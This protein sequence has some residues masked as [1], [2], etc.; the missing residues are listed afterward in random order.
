VVDDDYQR[1]SVVGQ[2]GDEHGRPQRPGPRQRLGDHGG[3]EVEQCPLVAGVAA[4]HLTYMTPDV[5]VSIVD[6]DRPPTARRYPDESLT[7]PG[8]G[9]NS[10]GD[11]F[12]G[13]G[14][15]EL[16]SRAEDED[17]PD[18]LRNRTG[19]HRKKREI[20][21]ACPIDDRPFD[22]E[23]EP[24]TGI[25][26][27]HDFSRRPPAGT[28][29]GQRSPGTTRPAGTGPRRSGTEVI[30]TSAKAVLIPNATDNAQPDLGRPAPRTRRR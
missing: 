3:G 23:P 24:G 13:A 10:L 14:Q 7:Q 4:A 5:E 30:G 6:P 21:G 16:R 18:L 11:Q 19:I 15:V 22:A 17:R 20:G 26:P 25:S 2:S 12:L 28:D 29:Q 8:N 9:R 1:D 27:A